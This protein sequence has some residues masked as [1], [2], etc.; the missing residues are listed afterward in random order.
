MKSSPKLTDPPEQNDL[1]PKKDWEPQAWVYLIWVV[2]GYRVYCK[3][4]YSKNPGSRYSQ[5]ITGM[6]ERPFRMHLLSCLS[7]EQA[8]LFEVMLHEHLKDYKARGEWFTHPNVRHFHKALN[9][10]LQEIFDLFHTFGYEPDFERI[11]LDGYRPVLHANGYVSH[12]SDPSVESG[13][14]E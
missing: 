2:M 13:E 10:K 1:E 7:V 12:V 14:G 4:G 3:I 6:P 11:D 5:I 9:S 8:Q